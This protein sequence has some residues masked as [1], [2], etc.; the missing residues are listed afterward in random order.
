MYHRGM[1]L[2]EMFVLCSLAAATSGSARTPYKQMFVFG[3]S[4][5]DIGEGSPFTN[6]STA[7]AY[8]ARGLGFELTPSNK[9]TTPDQ[10][11]DFA[12][13]GAQTG[14]DLGWQRGDKR[15][16]FGMQNQV[17][18]FAD[19]V[20]RG[21]SRF[22]PRTTLFFIAGGLND[23]KLPTETTVANLTS[24]VQTLYSLGARHFL[25]ALMPEAIPAFSAVGKRLN[26]A[27]ALIPPQ[28]RPQLPEAEIELSHWGPFFDEVMRNSSRY[29]ISNTADPC[30]THWFFN[31][32][33]STCST[34]DAHYYFLPAHPSTAVHKIVGAKLAAELTSWSK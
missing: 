14:S 2:V 19:H 10:S 18:D 5:S 1:R 7:V 21:Q 31:L 28:L 30:E 27:L 12:V 33:A 26:P 11:L 9:S 34:P 6:G 8:L 20:K 29:G 23:D 3:D 16:L 13:S 4:Y 17:Q 22:D 25:I 15:L 24:E 32:I